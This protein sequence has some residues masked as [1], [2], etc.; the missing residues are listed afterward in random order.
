MFGNLKIYLAGPLFTPYQQR[1]LDNVY[2]D[3]RRVGARVFSPYHNSQA[4][5]KGRAPKDCSPEDRRI[6]LE[7]NMSNL[8]CAAVFAWLRGTPGEFTD[9]GTV[10]EMGYAECL[11]VP[12]VGWVRR[13][14]SLKNVNLMIAANLLAVA[15]DDELVTLYA[16]F[17]EYGEEYVRKHWNPES[18]LEHES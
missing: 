4:I 8:N 3:L 7:Q 13:D 14:E 18:R 12:V 9:Q 1:T 2:G 10:W 5:W 6:V 17:V 16:S 11:A 15:Y